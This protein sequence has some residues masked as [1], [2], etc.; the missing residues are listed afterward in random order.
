MGYLK[1]TLLMSGVG[2]VFVATAILTHELAL[3]VRY[4]NAFTT[5]VGPIPAIPK[6]R[7]RTAVAFAM[8]AWAPLMIALGFATVAIE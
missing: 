1:T 2:M 7:W 6:P 8:L 4:R 5:S 3:E